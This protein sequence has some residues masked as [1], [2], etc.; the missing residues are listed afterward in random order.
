VSEERTLDH[1]AGEAFPLSA[2]TSRKRVVAVTGAT[3]FL[4]ENLIGVLEDDER[5]ERLVSVDTAPPRTALEKTRIYQVDLADATAEDRLSELLA[6]EGVDTVVHLAFLPSPTHA[7]AYGH[8]FESVGTM[9]VLN[10][11]RRSHVNKFVMW[12]QTVLYGARPDNPNFLTERH[13]L[14]AERSAP[15]FLDKIEAENEALRFGKPGQGRTVTILRTAPI[16]GPSVD[17]YL[18]R[19]LS[20]RLV[21]TVLGF[22]PLWQFL[23]E[24]DAV[25]ALL[26]AVLQDLPG[27]FNVAPDGVLPLS[28]AV[29]LAGRSPLPL[30]RSLSNTL[31]SAL[32]LAQVAEAPPAFIDYLQYICV[33]DGEHLQQ[34]TGFRP[35]YTSR[36]ALS[37][38][39]AAQHLRD[40]R[41]LSESIA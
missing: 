37:E 7:S 21:P 32:W 26:L 31:V 27:I 28:T 29:R 19:Y 40:V 1:P 33:A 6:A 3:S 17:N 35:L 10:A 22:D 2:R 12:S 30:P 36:E 14:R 18:T 4:G 15:F 16:V 13:P 34:V 8:E 23:H 24:A 5:I 20:H 11:C 39:A 25:R 9:R 38:Y 41:L